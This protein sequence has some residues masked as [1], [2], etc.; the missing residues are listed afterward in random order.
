MSRKHKEHPLL[1]ALD[2]AALLQVMFWRGSQKQGRT[3][4][5][6]SPVTRVITVMGGFQL[7]LGVSGAG[8]ELTGD[9]LWRRWHFS[10]FQGTQLREE[11][12]R[13]SLTERSMHGGLEAESH[14]WI[15]ELN[16]A[17]SLKRMRVGNEET[18][19]PK[20]EVLPCS[21]GFDLVSAG[22]E[23]LAI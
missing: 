1:P 19:Q 6:H 2:A 9:W 13:V 10:R 12:R 15:L 3:R 11:S 18:D 8:Q 4:M 20:R 16:N 14:G 5:V 21:A 17:S 7:R 22:V 23:M